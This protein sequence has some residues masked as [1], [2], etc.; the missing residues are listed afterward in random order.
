MKGRKN[1]RHD[2]NVMDDTMKAIM[3]ERLKKLQEHVPQEMIESLLKDNTIENL[4][5]YI[6]NKFRVIKLDINDEQV[7]WRLEMWKDMLQDSYANSFYRIDYDSFEFTVYHI[8]VDDIDDSYYDTA[9]FSRWYSNGVVP[10]KLWRKIEII[11]EHKM[12]HI[13]VH[14]SPKLLKELRFELGINEFEHQNMLYEAI[15][16]ILCRELNPHFENTSEL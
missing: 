1:T 6:E 12:R 9:L 15:L 14:M 16:N 7:S 13:D 11:I 4:L 10:R 3:Q 2:I 5:K 8:H